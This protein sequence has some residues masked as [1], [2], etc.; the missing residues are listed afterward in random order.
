MPGGLRVLGLDE[1]ARSHEPIVEAVVRASEPLRKLFSKEQRAFFAEHA[2]EGVELD[3]LSILGPIFVLK[4][5]ASARRSFGRRLVGE[6]WLY[7]DGSRIVE[8][9]TKC[10]PGRGLRRR[11]PGCA[12]SS[13]QRGIALADEQQTKTKTALE[14]FSAQLNGD[15]A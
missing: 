4:L 15:E 1:A 5:Q 11:R 2:P 10:L 14:F 3:D 7:P 6:M 9:S 12:R 13:K 8:L